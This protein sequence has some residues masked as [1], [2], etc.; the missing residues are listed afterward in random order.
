[1]CAPYLGFALLELG[2]LGGC[3]KMDLPEGGAA[4][5]RR[6]G[7]CDRE[8]INGAGGLLIRRWWCLER[9]YKRLCWLA[10][11]ASAE[12]PVLGR[13]RLAVYL[14]PECWLVLEARDLRNCCVPGFGAMRFVRR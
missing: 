2:L 3:A 9:G 1:M 14:V 6:F 7:C 13:F 4:G 11:A 8:L 10:G 12:V 5:R